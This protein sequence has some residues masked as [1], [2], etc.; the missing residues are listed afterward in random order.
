MA[1]GLA[2]QTAPAPFINLSLRCS[3]LTFTSKLISLDPFRFDELLRQRPL[4][5]KSN[6]GAHSFSHL[7]AHFVDGEA[8]RPKAAFAKQTATSLL[9]MISLDILSFHWFKLKQD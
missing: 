2:R 5:S 9:A 4:L 3:L 7:L 1:G 8:Q 6:D